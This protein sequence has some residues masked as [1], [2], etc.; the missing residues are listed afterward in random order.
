MA[1]KKGNGSTSVEGCG[2]VWRAVEKPAVS[3]EFECIDPASAQ[4]AAGW[5][6]RQVIRAIADLNAD[7]EN[8]AIDPKTARARLYALQTMLVA[9]KMQPTVEP[10][11]RRRL[12]APETIPMLEAVAEIPAPAD[13]LHRELTEMMHV[14]HGEDNA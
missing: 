12:R 5:G 11:A 1:G 7:L 4:N 9:M 3:K 2:R 10:P 6:T 14:T 13:D 8:D